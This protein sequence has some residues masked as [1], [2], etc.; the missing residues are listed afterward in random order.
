MPDLTEY[1]KQPYKVQGSWYHSSVMELGLQL[2]F[3]F[4]LLIAIQGVAKFC[5]K[6]H[7]EEDTFY[8]SAVECGG[9]EKQGPWKQMASIQ[10][11]RLTL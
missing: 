5:I 3:L 8:C 10:I 7:R 6:E 1:L 11:L 2:R 9:Q 4:A